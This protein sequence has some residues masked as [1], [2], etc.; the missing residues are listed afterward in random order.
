MSDRQP[1][2]KAPNFWEIDFPNSKPR[3]TSRALIG[4]FSALKYRLVAVLNTVGA[5][6]VYGVPACIRF[7]QSVHKIAPWCLPERIAIKLCLK[8]LRLQ[9]LLLKLSQFHL[10][11]RIRQC[12][13]SYLRREFG[14]GE[15]DF[16]IVCR[17]RFLE[18]VLNSR[19]EAS[20]L[21]SGG[22]GLRG[23]VG[24]LVKALEVQVHDSLR[25]VNKVQESIS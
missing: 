19:N 23:E 25:R 16:R 14:K 8:L 6:V 21:F 12:R 7:I 13:I 17:L 20:P 9:C 22:D 15:F 10:K 3:L 24:N 1:S 18:Q 4:V 5:N 2:S 11:L